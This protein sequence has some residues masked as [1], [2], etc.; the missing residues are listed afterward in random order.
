MKKL[1][2]LFALLCALLPA[3]AQYESFFGR[4]SWEYAAAYYVTCYTDEYDPHA[5]GPCTETFNF[6]FNHDDTLNINGNTYYSYC[7]DDYFNYFSIFLREDTVNGR[8]FAR[9][10]TDET[11]NEYLLCDLSLSVGDTFV[12]SSG[13]VHWGYYE[14]DMKMVVDS[15]GNPSG[16]KVIYL[17]LLNGYS[18]FY[19]GD[20]PYMTNEFNIS[21]RFM[22]GVGPM[23]GVCPPNY[24]GMENTGAL[25]CLYKDNNLYYMTHETLG[26]DQSTSDVPLYPGSSLQIYPN[27]TSNQV[28]LEFITEEEVS[29]T[30]IVRDIVGR[31]CRRFSVND[32]KTALDLSSLPQGVYTFTFVD[33]QNRKITK[34]IVKQ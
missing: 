4:E 8:L 15:I 19:G 13:S 27:P 7:H 25:L 24:Y 29:G 2:T 34:K 32:K 1:I 16:R 18:L 14:E 22:E 6:S 11:E 21:L 5:L 23:Y 30:V 3:R 12:L 33:Q 9:Y 17:T 28:T 20:V 31:V 10:S 26:C